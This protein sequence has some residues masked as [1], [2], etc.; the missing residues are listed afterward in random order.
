[1]F[2]DSRMD[3]DSDNPCPS[4]SGDTVVISP[5]SDIGG[6]QNSA[7]LQFYETRRYTMCRLWHKRKSNMVHRQRSLE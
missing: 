4:N 7:P 6:G 5:P 2:I 1:M 3:G